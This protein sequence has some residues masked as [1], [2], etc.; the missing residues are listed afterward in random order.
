MKTQ[1]RSECG[2]SS[3]PEKTI[4]EEVN[5]MEK[6]LQIVNARRIPL[7]TSL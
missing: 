1:A 6:L 3:F 7:V 5:I 4:V 2:A